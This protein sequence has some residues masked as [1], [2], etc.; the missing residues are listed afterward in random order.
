MIQ[1]RLEWPMTT[2]LAAWKTFRRMS[3]E[4]AATATHLV[5]RSHWPGNRGAT[6]VDIGCGDG[7]LMEEI[8]LQSPV[9]VGEVRLIDPDPELLVEAVGC[10]HQTRL[11]KRVIS[12]QGDLDEVYEQETVGASAIL[13]VHL[14]Y[15][16]EKYSLT[17]L[18]DK[19]PIGVPLYVVLDAPSSI[20]TTLWK[21]TAPKYHQRS[22]DAHWMIQGADPNAYRVSSSSVVSTIQNPLAVR[23]SDVRDALLSILSYSP[24]NE[25]TDRPVRDWIEATLRERMIKGEIGCESTCYEVVRTA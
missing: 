1:A 9:T 12:V 5:S 25:N 20:F 23:R 10:V 2:Y 6:L 22:L 24:V 15:L 13:A 16:L 11:A 19:L 3:N 4:N 8:L 14:V 21:K 7:R 18:L 17:T